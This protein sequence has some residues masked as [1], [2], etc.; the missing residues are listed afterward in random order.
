ML[1]TA[2]CDNKP[3]IP[4]LRVAHNSWPG[5]EPLPLAEDEKLYKNIRVI[6]Y[7]VA[8]ATEVIRAFEQD[9]VD[10]AAVTLDE[11]IVFQ[12]RSKEPVYIIAVTDI[13]HGADVI[14]ATEEISS[15]NDLKGKRVG[16]E[17]TAL[18]AFFLTRAIETES[19]LN[20]NQLKIIPVLYGQH[21]QSFMNN[22]IDAVVTFE[23][24]KSKI[25]QNKGHVIFDS[26]S[27]KNEIIDVLIAK[28]ST[29]MNKKNE[30]NELIK[31]YFESLV[32]I[33]N[34]PDEAHKKMASY[35]D[36][37]VGGFK[38]SLEG[39]KIPDK[40]ENYLLLSGAS[41]ALKLSIDKLSEFLMKR[42]IVSKN[43]ADT[44]I[45]TDEF[46]PAVQ[47]K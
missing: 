3:S 33:K 12:N 34:N 40:E 1:H 32:Y 2:S 17:S 36:V 24:V 37:S 19:N 45:I 6:N 39:L 21:Y 14:I 9:I 29:V 16:V 4:T 22:E 13:S 47:G 15:L 35:E 46:L 41:P 5:Y 26:T 28:K 31:G 42:N 38:K 20:L 25:L 23:P 11:A 44:V 18:G 10:V 8:S 30:L 7:R 43:T 27:I